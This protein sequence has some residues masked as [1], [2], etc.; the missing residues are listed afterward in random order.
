MQ[1]KK[2]LATEFNVSLRTMNRAI[3]EDLGYSAYCKKTCQYLT[4]NIK[5]NRLKRCTT[6]LRKHDNRSIEN[7]LFTDE[8]IFGIEEKFNK[9]M[10]KCMVK[11]VNQSIHT[12]KQSVEL[13]ILHKLWFGQ[14]LA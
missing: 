4:Y 8:K 14:V 6:L 10:I 12:L 9:K 13:I 5:L 11:T 7:I 3:N 1:K 2:K